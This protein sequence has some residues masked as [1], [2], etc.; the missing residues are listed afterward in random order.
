LLIVL[1][2]PSREDVATCVPLTPWSVFGRFV[3][4]LEGWAELLSS[5]SGGNEV[6]E[7]NPPVQLHWAYQ[8]Q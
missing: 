8:I 4:G 1:P 2:F 7:P 5:V 3:H 6:T